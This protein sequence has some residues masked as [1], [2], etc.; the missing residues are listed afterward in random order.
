MAIGNYWECVLP[1]ATEA[2][3]LQRIVSETTMLA[4]QHFKSWR[5]E[6]DGQDVGGAEFAF[7]GSPA[8]ELRAVVHLVK[9]QGRPQFYL[10]SAFP[11]I[12]SGAPA[13]L[14]LFG[15]DTNHF[16]LEGFVD[17]AM[18][19]GPKVKFFDPLFA[20]NKGKYRPGAE[21]NFTLGGVTLDL[22]LATRKPVRITNPETVAKMREP[23]S[24][25][26]GAMASSP[27][28]VEVDTSQA[29][30][31]V[32]A[33]EDASDYYFFQGPVRMIQSATFLDR[34]FLVF[35]TAVVDFQGGDL[36]VDIYMDRTRFL[37][38]AIPT[39][40]DVVSGTLWLQGC[41]VEGG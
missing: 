10:H 36:A 28:Y 20:I 29:K 21:Y 8:G 39:V 9:P 34:P 30:I 41:L 13:V 15:V 32:R 4:Q 19:K 14:T 37:T 11:W 17:A 40:G 33:A 6:P 2:P 24:S 31:L 1:E 16:G 3:P 23:E 7:M 18:G 27:D 12:A 38:R 5:F 22:A 35:R 25:A 26:T